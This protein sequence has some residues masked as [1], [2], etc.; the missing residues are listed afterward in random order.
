MNHEEGAVKFIDPRRQ[1]RYLGFLSN[2]KRREKFLGELAHCKA[3]DPKW[4]VAI[5]PNQQN[6]SSIANLLVSRGAPANCW[7]ISEN[8]TLDAQEM[9][10]V[11]ALEETIGQD[12]GTFLS[13]I[14]GKLAYFE[15][16]DGRC[17]LQ[18]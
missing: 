18:R 11:K 15:N 13:C 8:S 3:L 10:L 4:V 2:P 5:M 1:E 12:M 16:E 14:P 17:I 9:E 6:P 7:I